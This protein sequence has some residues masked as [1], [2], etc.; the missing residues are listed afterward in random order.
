MPL[1]ERWLVGLRRREGISL[2]PLRATTDAE[3]G[4]ALE[5][6]ERRL[7]PFRHQGLLR[8][9]GE[10]WRLQDPQGLALSNRVLRELLAWW[11]ALP[12][13]LRERL[14]RLAAPGPGPLPV[15]GAPSG[16]APR[17]PGGGPPAGAG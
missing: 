12:P 4:A 9:E 16:A 7:A 6:L 1:D 11:Q 5:A 3:L 8:V 14:N 17:S 15:A 2:A 13:A 10:R